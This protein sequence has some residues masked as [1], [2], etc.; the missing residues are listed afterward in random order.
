MVLLRKAHAEAATKLTRA[1][2]LEWLRRGMHVF[3]RPGRR[4]TA[5]FSEADL[6][7]SHDQV[8]VYEASGSSPNERSS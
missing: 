5:A 8:A 6:R 3:G 4:W 1:E 2:R 7:R